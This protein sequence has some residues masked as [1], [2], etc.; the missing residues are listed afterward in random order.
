[1]RDGSAPKVLLFVALVALGIVIG[2][3]LTRPARPH[4]VNL[5][6]ST[7]ILKCDGGGDT[8]LIS[9]PLLIKPYEWAPAPRIAQ[10]N[11]RAQVGSQ[12]LASADLRCN[13]G[14]SHCDP[15]PPP[16]GNRMESPETECAFGPSWTRS[17]LGQS[18]SRLF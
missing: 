14:R 17:L 7:M 2:I 9:A 11:S 3:V 4:T 1:M 10:P 13:N 16:S 18:P 6:G 15:S 5:P 8:C 12:L